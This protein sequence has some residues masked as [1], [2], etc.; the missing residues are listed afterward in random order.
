[1]QGD[2]NIMKI[3]TINGSPK[4]GNS[5]SK[6]MIGYVM[7]AMSKDNEIE[8]I[9]I[10]NNNSVDEIIHKIKAS[11][12]LIFCFPLYVDSIPAHLLEF[13]I[14]IE[15]SGFMNKDTMVYCIINNGFFEGGQTH[16]AVNQMKHWCK[17]VHAIWGQAIGVGAGE[18]IPFISNIPLGHGPNKN[19]GKA[20]HDMSFNILNKKSGKDIYVSPNWIRY[21]WRLQSTLLVWY[22]R[23]RKNGLHFKDLFKK[24]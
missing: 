20:I 19:L 1:M 7:Q 6:I 15:K 21:V 2:R 3:I 18:M 14:A 24:V 5:T 12:I 11:D 17:S 23:A 9:N 16:I 10:R 22:P 4:I 8:H 13:L